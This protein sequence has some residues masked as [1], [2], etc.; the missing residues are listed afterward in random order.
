[1]FPLCIRFAVSLYRGDVLPCY[2]D[3]FIRILYGISFPVVKV[4]LDIIKIRHEYAWF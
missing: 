3:K 4:K 2:H 1:M